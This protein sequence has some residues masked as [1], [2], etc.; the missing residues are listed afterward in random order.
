MVSQAKGAQYGQVFT[1]SGTANV[2]TQ[3]LTADQYRN[4]S[5]RVLWKWNEVDTSEI[6]TRVVPCS[7]NPG[8]INS[9]TRAFIAAGAGNGVGPRW[10]FNLGFAAASTSTNAG[11]WPILSNGSPVTLPKRFVMHYRAARF[12]GTNMG[13]CH[14]GLGVWNGNSSVPYA[15]GVIQVSSA[16]DT[17]I[18]RIQQS[19][20]VTTTRPWRIMSAS[21]AGASVVATN[22]N[23]NVGSLY[24][25]SYT[26]D[27]STVSTP[28]L[29]MAHISSASGYAQNMETPA[30]AIV[31]NRSSAGAAFLTDT[32]AIDAGWNGKTLDQLCFMFI[33]ST[34]GSTPNS[35]VIEMGDMVVFKHSNDE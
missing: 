6:G 7:I 2:S 14:F 35:C 1:P 12:S 13:Q 9:E 4:N 28:P 16:T 32:G 11:L 31:P 21:G 29:P 3:V 10:Q 20:A 17:G 15:V 19:D 33:G 8:A 18:I 22:I 27:P 30:S 25:I 23:N 26:I 34:T 24:D 5:S